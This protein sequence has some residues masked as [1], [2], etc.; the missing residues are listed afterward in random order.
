MGTE[1]KV[2]KLM[3]DPKNIKHLGGFLGGYSGLSSLC[4][5]SSGGTSGTTHKGVW[6]TLAALTCPDC[7]RKFVEFIY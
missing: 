1:W 6:N 7:I 2:V 3:G 4:G 5:K